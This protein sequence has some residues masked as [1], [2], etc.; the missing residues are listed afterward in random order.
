ME[1][2]S[3]RMRCSRPTARPLSS[4]QVKQII[5]T[6]VKIL[7][8]QFI[9]QSWRFDVKCTHALVMGP[10]WPGCLPS[11]LSMEMDRVVPHSLP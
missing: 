8:Q 1:N 9:P 3:T 4:H 10:K 11:E 5:F 2:S 7:A 6:R